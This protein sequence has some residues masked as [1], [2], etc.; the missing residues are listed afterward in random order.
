M[1][2][3]VAYRQWDPETIQVAFSGSA[4]GP[5]VHRDRRSVPRQ[6]ATPAPRGDAAAFDQECAVARHA[7][8][9]FLIRIY[10]AD[11]PQPRDEQTALGRANHFFGG[12]ISP[13]KNQI[14]RRFAV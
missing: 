5:A 13:C 11:V 2:T 4:C 6:P 1:R 3:T 8:E 12:S 9:N 14:E 10:F 7:G